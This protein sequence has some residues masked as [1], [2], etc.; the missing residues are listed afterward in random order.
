MKKRT[1]SLTSISYSILQVY[2]KGKIKVKDFRMMVG[3]RNKR[4]SSLST[5]A[6]HCP[7]LLQLHLWRQ[8]WRKMGN[9]SSLPEPMLYCLQTICKR[10]CLTPPHGQIPASLNQNLPKISPQEN[11][12]MEGWEE[13]LQAESLGRGEG[14]DRGQPSSPP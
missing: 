12:N 3:N 10:K 2:L 11:R 1:A 4:W 6:T 8:L 7:P 5:M 13:A 9:E 14:M